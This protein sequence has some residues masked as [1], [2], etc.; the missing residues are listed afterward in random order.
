MMQRSFLKPG[1]PQQTSVGGKY[2]PPYTGVSSG[3]SHTLIGHPP[4]PDT[5]QKQNSKSMRRRTKKRQLPYN[6]RSGMKLGHENLFHSKEV[7]SSKDGLEVWGQEYTHDPVTT[8]TCSLTDVQCCNLSMTNKK[9]P[10]TPDALIVKFYKLHYKFP[11][12]KT[13]RISSKKILVSKDTWCSDYSHQGHD[14][15]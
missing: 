13:S 10:P 4:R 14:A 12:N 8:T 15:M 7:S 1:W 6:I 2:V 5:A 3:V 11:A 9:L